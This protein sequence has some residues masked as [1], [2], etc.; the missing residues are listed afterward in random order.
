MGVLPQKAVSQGA[1]KSLEPT[2]AQCVQRKAAEE[3]T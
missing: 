3:L 1:A 2:L